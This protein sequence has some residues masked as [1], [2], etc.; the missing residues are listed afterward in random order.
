MYTTLFFVLI[1]IITFSYLLERVLDILNIRNMKSEIPDEVKDVYDSD[2]YN[3]Q[4]LYQRTNNR[5]SIL[6]NSFSFVLILLMFILGGFAWIDELARNYSDNAIWIALLFFGIIMFA[7]ELL[8]IPFSLYDTF[9]IEE[10][11]GFNKT[12]A[13]TYI[14]DKIKS[15][16]LT[17]IIGGGA[18]ALVVWFYEATQELFW[19]YAWAFVT[20]FMIFMMMFY[21]NLIVPLFNKQTPL[22]EGELR[23]AIEEFAQK[24]GFKLNNIYKIDGSKRSTKANAYFTGLGPKKRI[25]LYDT[26]INDISVEEIVAVL[27]HEVGH[28]KHKHSLKGIITSILQTGITLY[29]LSLFIAHPSLSEALGSST[30]SFHL[31]VI[32]FGILYSPINLFLGIISNVMSR[33]HEYEA[34]KYARENHNSE[35]LIGA[36]KKL[37]RNNLSN[38]TPHPAMVFFH[39]SHPTLLQRIQALKKK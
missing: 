1:A 30:P 22:E 35:S 9:V 6:T 16:I 33:K 17:A 15:W 24:V 28:N 7:S 8:N 36:L 2:K 13:K 25:V 14:L 11:F 37:S 21:S 32:A 12:T 39:Y 20:F 18:L 38:L 19:I 31:G 27:A 3:K 29:L 23:T 5:F 26:L 34:D 4:Q 10:K